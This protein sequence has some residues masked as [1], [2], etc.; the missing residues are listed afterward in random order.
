[1]NNPAA[2]VSSEHLQQ[3]ANAARALE[4]ADVVI[5]AQYANGRRPVLIIDKPPTFVVGSI[6]RRTPNAL[7]GVTEVY[8]AS[9]LACQLEWMRDV[10]GT[11]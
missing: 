6:K 4:A 10:P 1:M 11:A 9:F 7:G 8:A 2:I 5:V 3:A